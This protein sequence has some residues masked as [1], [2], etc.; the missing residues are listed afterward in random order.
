MR[1][2]LDPNVLVSAAL[3][4][5]GPSAQLVRAARSGRFELVVCPTLLVEL[6]GVL[7]R[8][9]LRR[10]LSADEAIRYVEGIGRLATHMDDPATGSRRSRDPDDDY[11]L[12]LAERCDADLLVSG[13][14][15]LID[16]DLPTVVTPRVALERLANTETEI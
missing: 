16:L 3:S 14:R 9:R 15:D 4:D 8:P 13:D 1:V 7:A 2:V 12:A 10:Y 6:G 11:L 5:R